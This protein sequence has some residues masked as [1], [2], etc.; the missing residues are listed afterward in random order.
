MRLHEIS[1]ELSEMAPIA[2]QAPG[3]AKKLKVTKQGPAFT[4]LTD[5]NGV[6]TKVPNKPG[7]P[8]MIQKHKD[9]TA[10]LNTGEKGPVPTVKPGDTVTVK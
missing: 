9:G 10:T 1:S 7:E 4:E 6:V 2:T 3:Q 5:D 8:G